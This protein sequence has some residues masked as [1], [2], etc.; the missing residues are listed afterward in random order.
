M[1]RQITV[2]VAGKTG[3]AEYVP[4]GT[5]PPTAL[6]LPTHAPFVAFAPYDNPQIAIAVVVYGAGKDL[7]SRSR[8]GR[9]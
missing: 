5:S 1:L 4:E 6:K 9:R 3:S 7:T 8:R 2:P